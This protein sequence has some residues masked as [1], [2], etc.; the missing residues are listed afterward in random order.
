M[1]SL[2]GEEKYSVMLKSLKEI[3]EPMSRGEVDYIGFSSLCNFWL[4]EADFGWGKP[5]W[6]SS[7]EASGSIFMNLGILFD[8]RFGDG[9]EAWN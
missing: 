7:G 4:Y 3:E 8:T 6:V 5:I 9:I 1:K 2:Q